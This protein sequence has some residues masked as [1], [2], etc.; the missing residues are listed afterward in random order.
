[1]Y[2]NLDKQKKIFFK[3]FVIFFLFAFLVINWGDVSWLFNYKV[4]TKIVGDF[5]QKITFSVSKQ[6][7]GG[8]RKLLERQE[9]KCVFSEKTDWLEIP[10]IN[11]SVPIIFPK[12]ENKEI[13]FEKLLDE[14]A[15]FYPSSSL[16]GEK[17]E[18]IILGHSAP[19]NWPKV[20]Y[21]WIFSRLSELEKGDEI[22]IYYDY[23]KYRYIVFD[24]KILNK[25]ES[26][27]VFNNQDNVLVLTS[28]WP[29]G[30]DY[31]RIIVGAKIKY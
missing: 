23:C 14:G 31:K 13:D 18:T 3:Y 17:G 12:K 8:T 7:G 30:K 27:P 20:R 19:L 15:V 16:P 9:T 6:G 28:C 4:V 21:E 26:I 24:K 29:P 10:K 2:F 11:L 22:I 25:G 1:M 5:L